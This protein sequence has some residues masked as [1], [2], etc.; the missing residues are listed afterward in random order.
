MHSWPT[1][2]YWRVRWHCSHGTATCS[3][4]SGKLRQ[5]MIEADAGAPALRGVALIAFLAELARRARRCERWQPKQSLP[6][7][8]RGHGRG[9][10]GVT[11]DLLVPPDERPLGVAR[12]VEG[13]RLPLLVA[14]AVAAVL[15]EAP[16]VRVLPLVAADAFARQLVLQVPACGGS[17]CRRCDRAPRASAKPVSFLWSNLEFFQ[18]L[19]EWQSAHLGPRSPWCTSSGCV[20][21]DALARACPCSGCRSDS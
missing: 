10:A 15:A 18:P 3:P 14:V 12:V 4:T 1:S 9:V 6:Q 8:L 7:L 17:R 21:R 2:R 5:V 13:R 19:V 20:A 11:V 16:G